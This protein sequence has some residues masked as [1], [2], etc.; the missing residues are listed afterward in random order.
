MRAMQNPLP[1][2]GDRVAG[3][4][5]PGDVELLDVRAVD[6]IEIGVADALRTAA[7][8]LPFAIA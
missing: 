6:L 2:S 3:I 5:G 7:V 1:R 4:V 8:H